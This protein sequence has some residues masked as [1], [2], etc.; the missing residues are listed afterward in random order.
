MF[1]D[2]LRARRQ[3]G[4]QRPARKI[5]L[6]DVSAPANWKLLRHLSPDWGAFLRN[7]AHTFESDDLQADVSNRVQ[8]YMS[9]MGLWRRQD[10]THFN[11]TIFGQFPLAF[12]QKGG[13]STC[14]AYY[15]ERDFQTL[16]SLSNVIEVFGS[17]AGSICGENFD[18]VRGNYTFGLPIGTRCVP[19][20][21]PQGKSR[22]R[23]FRNTG[24]NST[25]SNSARSSANQDH[26]K[27]CLCEM[28]NVSLQGR[29]TKSSSWQLI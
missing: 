10:Q 19:I 13:S 14:S 23:P 5:L 9:D 24:S 25:V 17:H 1:G 26:E 20:I 15:L 2:D 22:S 18:I 12:L 16:Y 7:L 28:V 27:S 21:G 29:I 6:S 3:P 8:D 4:C 11:G